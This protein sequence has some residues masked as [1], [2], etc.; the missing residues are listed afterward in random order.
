MHSFKEQILVFLWFSLLHQP[1]WRCTKGRG[2]WRISLEWIP[3]GWSVGVGH[4]AR[5]TLLALSQAS[6]LPDYI[7]MGGLGS[8][9]AAWDFPAKERSTRGPT[10]TIH[11]QLC[12]ERKQISGHTCLSLLSCHQNLVI[13]HGKVIKLFVL[14]IGRSGSCAWNSV[15][16]VLSAGKF[17]RI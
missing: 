9:N 1:G 12:T 6:F 11:H 4:R 8:L 10:T 3:R 2:G 5:Q 7:P 13:S 15:W 14:T 17:S 16:W